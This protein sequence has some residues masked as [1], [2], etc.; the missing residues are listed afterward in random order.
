MKSL[1]KNRLDAKMLIESIFFSFFNNKAYTVGF[2]YYI[3]LNI[4]IYP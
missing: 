1:S 4:F 3:T 2:K